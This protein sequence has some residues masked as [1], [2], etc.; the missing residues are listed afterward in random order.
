M[1][2]HQNL[3]ILGTIPAAT[4]YQQV[5]HEPDETVET[6][7]TLNLI[8][9]ERADQIEPRNPRSTHRTSFR[10]PQGVLGQRGRRV[11]LVITQT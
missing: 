8:D 3:S 4:Q 9:A 5:E 6:G 11:V 2:Q 1:A 10:H 7:H